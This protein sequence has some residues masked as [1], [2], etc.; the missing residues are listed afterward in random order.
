M[1]RIQLIGLGLIIICGAISQ[2][3]A[4]NQNQLAV[5]LLAIGAVVGIL[6]VISEYFSAK[7]E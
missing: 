1:K 6:M 4:A 5:W 2:W 7:K 3:T